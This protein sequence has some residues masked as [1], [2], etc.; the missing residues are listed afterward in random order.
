[1]RF[2]GLAGVKTLVLA[3][4]GAMTTSTPDDDIDHDDVNLPADRLQ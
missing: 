3:D 2:V 4:N 1:M